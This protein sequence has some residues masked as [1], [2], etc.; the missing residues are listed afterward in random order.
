[1]G[2]RMVC[3]DHVELGLLLQ[4]EQHTLLQGSPLADARLS[5]ASPTRVIKKLEQDYLFDF[6]HRG[7]RC[8]RLAAVLATLSTR[9]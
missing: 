2:A 3:D 4:E 8:L 9:C 7:R 6:V 5:G 1:M